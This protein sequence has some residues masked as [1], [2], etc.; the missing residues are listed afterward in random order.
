MHSPAFS[1][2]VCIAIIIFLKG[3]STS[4]PIYEEPQLKGKSW[5]RLGAGSLSRPWPW[6]IADRSQ[7]TQ[8]HWG[9]WT[10]EA[11]R[12]LARPGV[13][14]E[15]KGSRNETTNPTEEPGE[16]V[17]SYHQ[18]QAPSCGLGSEAL[19]VW[20]CRSMLWLVQRPR[21]WSRLLQG[22][23]DT[24]GKLILRIDG[25]LAHWPGVV[26]LLHVVGFVKAARQEEAEAPESETWPDP[27]LSREA[28]AVNSRSGRAL[29]VAFKTRL[30]F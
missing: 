18:S 8:G 14:G 7:E 17:S 1:G 3:Q 2:C 16:R 13:H 20:C 4:P 28:S 11:D 12:A 5:E 24:Y 22:R 30:S 29:A 21:E 23:G 27:A 26:E 15:W 19:P 6:G 25:P 9:L 10:P